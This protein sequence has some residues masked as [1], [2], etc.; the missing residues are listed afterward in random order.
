MIVVY[1]SDNLYD[2]QVLGIWKL[3]EPFETIQHQNDP[4]KYLLLQL[5]LTL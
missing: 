1:F 4:L 5:L 2:F 3:A